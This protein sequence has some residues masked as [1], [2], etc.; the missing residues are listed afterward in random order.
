[1]DKGLSTIFG[2]V[3]D[4]IHKTLGHDDFKIALML[5]L[6]WC[7]DEEATDI[8]SL[9]VDIDSGKATL[10]MRDGHEVIFHY[11]TEGRIFEMLYGAH[12]LG[13]PTY[14][15]ERRSWIV[16]YDTLHGDLKAGSI[17]KTEYTCRYAEWRK[18]QPEER[19]PDYVAL[20]K[21]EAKGE[22]S[23]DDFNKAYSELGGQKWTCSCSRNRDKGCK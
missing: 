6:G 13:S 3:W 21:A 20:L 4:E 5:P 1:M 11:D 17:S 22:V 18:R 2:I 7:G 8:K 15:I 10:T 23:D 16:E 12:R 9:K 14:E 19:D